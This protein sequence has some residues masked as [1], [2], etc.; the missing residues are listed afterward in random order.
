[1]ITIEHEAP[2]WVFAVGLWEMS[3]DQIFLKT[4]PAKH[5]E[6]GGQPYQDQ[7]LPMAIKKISQNLKPNEI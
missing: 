6:L 3:Q 1:M 2:M 5:P 4:Q 7:I